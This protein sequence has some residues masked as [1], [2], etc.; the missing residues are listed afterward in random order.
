ML[1]L[2]ERSEKQMLH[3]YILYAIVLPLKTF[4]H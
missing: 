1:H 3:D 2:N 4:S